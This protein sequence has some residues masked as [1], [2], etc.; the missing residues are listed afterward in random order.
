MAEAW[1]DFFVATAGAAA[2][3]AGLIIVAMSVNIAKI[4]EI[5]AM[6]ARAAA[7][8]SS[9]VLIVVV[10][11]AGLIPGQAD[12]LYG[13]EV[14][15]LTGLALGFA[16]DAAVRILRHQDAGHGPRALKAAVPVLQVVPF[17]IGGVLLVLGSSVGLGWLAAGFI[18]VF[19]GSV[20]GAWV[21]LV[22][23]LR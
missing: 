5:P 20:V 3:L 10:A 4:I 19:I 17:A 23:I 9:L 15:I 11:A 7:T 13:V 14:L 1:N 21:L 8:I 2:A 16:I 6:P 12:V 18:L 22:E